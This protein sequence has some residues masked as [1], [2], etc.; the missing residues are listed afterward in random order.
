MVRTSIFHF[1]VGGG[2][3]DHTVNVCDC[4]LIVPEIE[5][6]L[7]QS[8]KSGVKKIVCIESSMVLMF[9]HLQKVLLPIRCH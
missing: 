7:T 8:R 6:H 1:V 2:V 9:C 5:P 4:A 3:T